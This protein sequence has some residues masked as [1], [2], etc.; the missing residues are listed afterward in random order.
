[1]NDA[2]KNNIAFPN[3]THPGT[4]TTGAFTFESM[5]FGHADRLKRNHWSGGG[6]CNVTFTSDSFGCSGL[7]ALDFSSRATAA[8]RS[9]CG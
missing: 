2:L 6:T 7:R 1:V 4:P 9:T 3:E 5:C 8:T